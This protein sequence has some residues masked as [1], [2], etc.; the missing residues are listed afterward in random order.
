MKTTILMTCLLAG[1]VCVAGVTSAQEGRERPDFA[2]LDA[3]GDGALTLAEMQAHGAARFA[4]RDANGDGALSA[5][6]LG[7]EGPG[8]RA[9]RMLEELD[10]NADGILQK[11]ELEAREGDRLKRMFERADSDTDGVIT[12]AEF[13]ALEAQRG[14]RQGNRPQ[15]G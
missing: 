10:A 12:A 14:E 13:E 2:V 9:A 3:N 7:G 6:E 15:R 5:D 8:K 4:T 11:A 1:A